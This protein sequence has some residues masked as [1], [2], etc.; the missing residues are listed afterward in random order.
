MYAEPALPPL[1]SSRYAPIAAVS[2]LIETEWP[3]E[4]FAAASL[5]SSLPI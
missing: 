2:P 3:K 5:A 1:S 4:S